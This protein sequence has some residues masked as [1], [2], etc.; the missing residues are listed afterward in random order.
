MSALPAGYAVAVSAILFALGLF[1]LAA[2]RSAVRILLGV[3]LM[4]NA[5]VLN[6]VAFGRD[7]L[8]PGGA[9]FA[10]TI[11]AGAAAEAAVGLALVFA[12]F[13]IRHRSDIEIQNELSR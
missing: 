4:L 12:L 5:S 2:H 9:V 3:E 10:I 1:C 8:D 13:T 11:M 7:S 6:F